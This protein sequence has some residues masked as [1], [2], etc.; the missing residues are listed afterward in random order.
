MEITNAPQKV[1]LSN[2][3]DIVLKF[4]G[5]TLFLVINNSQQDDCIDMIDELTMR[6]HGQLLKSHSKYKKWPNI[7][8]EIQ[9]ARDFKTS[10]IRKLMYI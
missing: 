8:M 3:M 1:L 9:Y 5:E 2:K 6:K 10:R 7:Q 4:T